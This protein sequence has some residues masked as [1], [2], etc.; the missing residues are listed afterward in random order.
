MRDG[1]YLE[2]LESMRV[3]WHASD[4]AFDMRSTARDEQD[5]ATQ[6]SNA[7]TAP[8]APG[9]VRFWIVLRDDRGGVDFVIS[10]VRIVP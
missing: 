5:V 2:P 8:A 9:D 4:G 7:W 3:A 10:D 6:S 1:A